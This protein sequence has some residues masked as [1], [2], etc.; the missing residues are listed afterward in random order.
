VVRIPNGIPVAR[1][2]SPPTRPIPGLEE[3]SG[4]VVGT[5]A[6][7]RAV[8]N[9]PRLVR[10][11]AAAAPPGARLVIVGEGPERPAIEAEAEASGVADRLLMPASCRPRGWIGHSILR[12]VVRQRTIPDLAG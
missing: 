12:F 11:F 10:A 5:V 1:F 6:G 3:G 7:L 8:K 2:Q 4:P 9:L